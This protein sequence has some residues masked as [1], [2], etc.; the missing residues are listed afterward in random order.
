MRLKQSLPL[1]YFVLIR[2]FMYILCLNKVF[3]LSV[4]K[5]IFV[6]QRFL[7]VFCRD[8]TEDY[9]FFSTELWCLKNV[10]LNETA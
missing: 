5:A 10:K 4:F 8:S 1:L 3:V 7:R 6:Y 9:D 2:I